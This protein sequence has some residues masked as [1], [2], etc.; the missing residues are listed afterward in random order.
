M[1][2]ISYAQN[3]EDVMLYRALKD[4][5]H[6][7]YIDVGANDPTENSVTK[8]FYK[9]GWRGINIEPIP[10][11]IQKFYDE[12]LRD[13][14]LPV[15]VGNYSGE[16]VIHHVVGASGLSTHD[17]SIAKEFTKQFNCSLKK[18]TV[19]IRTLDSICE[20][21]KISQIHFLKIDVEGAEKSVLEGFSLTHLRPW[22]IVI[23]S[24]EPTKPIPTHHAWEDLLI[25]RNY[26]FVYFDGLNRFYIATE[27]LHLASAFNAP[28]NYFDNFKR[29]EV[30]IL[31][32]KIKEY[33]IAF[34]RQQRL[35]ILIKKALFFLRPQ[36]L[37]LLIKKVLFIVYK[38]GR[39]IPIAASFI[40]SILGFFPSFKA[41]LQNII[42]WEMKKLPL[43]QTALVPEWLQSIS[44]LLNKETNDGDKQIL[45]EV[46]NIMIDDGKTGIHR[47]VR[48]LISYFA[49]ENPANHRIEPVYFDEKGNLC[50]ARTL[51]F[52]NKST[53]DSLLEFRNEDILFF[54]DL[55]LNISLIKSKIEKLKNHKIKLYFLVY[56]ILPL[57]HPEWFPDEIS[58]PFEKWFQFILN[59]ADGMICISQSVIN[60]IENFLKDH[61]LKK[62]DKLKLDYF[63]LG[64]DIEHCLASKG[65]IKDYNQLKAAFAS[66]PSFLIVSCIAP[67]KGHEQTLAAFEHLWALGVDVNLIIIGRPVFENKLDQFIKILSS[68]P[69]RNKRLFWYDN[70]SDE[71]LIDC[72]KQTTAVLIPS[73]GEGFGIPLIEAAKHGAPLIVRDLPVFREIVKGDYVSYFTGKSPLDLANAIQ[74]WLLLFKNQ[75]VPESKHIRWQTWSESAKQLLSIILNDNWHP[76]PKDQ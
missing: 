60:D 68:H 15:A 21:H 39:R 43:T 59:E 33:E 9:R 67:R 40:N 35:K 73:E 20:E 65:F 56:D 32:N 57:Q 54:L 30:E 8:A 51:L 72:Y 17:F 46:S 36:G 18:I 2:F 69:E 34:L 66:R 7:F 53:K 41:K 38:T 26:Q 1:T 3:Y 19:P 29:V 11:C 74:E 50:Y 24:T 64:A 10:E 37:K 52:G 22:I 14:N 62:S 61:N 42:A 47:V 31:E 28:P 58:E 75:T 55:N 12:R 16:S 63:H 44:L 27:Q 70:V 5:P 25:Q 23:E 6:G 45:L 76:I 13:V 48:S 49:H 4:I 71:M